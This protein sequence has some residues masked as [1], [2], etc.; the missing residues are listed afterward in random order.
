MIRWLKALFADTTPHV[1]RVFKYSRVGTR[2]IVWENRY[3]GHD[4]ARTAGQAVMFYLDSA[5]KNHAYTFEVYKENQVPNEEGQTV[6]ACPACKGNH[7]DFR[8]LWI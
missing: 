4:T 5:D 6:F 3:C 2:A 8:C 7:S 1:V